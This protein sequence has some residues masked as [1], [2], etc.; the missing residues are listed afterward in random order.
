[1]SEAK[2]SHQA[3]IHLHQKTCRRFSVRFLCISNDPS[4][5]HFFSRGIDLFS[6]KTQQ[7]FQCLLLTRST[8][9]ITIVCIY[10]DK[11]HQRDSSE[12]ER[13]MFLKKKV[14]LADE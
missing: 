2:V 3:F 8:P 1:M 14:F 9:G 6:S 5:F 10:R 11:I 12:W 4:F 13:G 7:N